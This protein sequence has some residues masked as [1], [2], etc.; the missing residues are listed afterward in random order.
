MLIMVQ[1]VSE[2]G[3]ESAHIICVKVRAFLATSTFPIDTTVFRGESVP[4]LKR[5]YF[6]RP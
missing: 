4:S 3:N 2:C 5:F 1:K 6:Q